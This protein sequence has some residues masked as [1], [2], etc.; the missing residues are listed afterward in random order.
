[1]LVLEQNLAQWVECWW[2]ERSRMYSER[3]VSAEDKGKRSSFH[4]PP[5]LLELS[6]RRLLQLRNK[7]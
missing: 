1:M 2:V 3:C 6:N 5:F 4:F 7:L